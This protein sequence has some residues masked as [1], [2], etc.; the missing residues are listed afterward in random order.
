MTPDQ[1]AAVRLA[2]ELGSDAAAERLGL[3]HSAVSTLRLKARRELWFQQI[4]AAALTLSKKLDSPTRAAKAL[5]I[6]PAVVSKWRAAA[7]FKGGAGVYGGDKP[8][9][10]CV[11]CGDSLPEPGLC[12][13]ECRRDYIEAEGRA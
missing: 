7:G 12:S 2:L 4:Q 8:K 1:E 6:L 3:S 5:K 11:E 10:E 13:D 9:D